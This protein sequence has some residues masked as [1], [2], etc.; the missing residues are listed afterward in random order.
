MKQK[1]KLLIATLFVVLFGAIWSLIAKAQT[2]PP[3]TDTWLPLIL[4]ELSSGEPPTF[5][6]T[7]TPVVI[8][9]TATPSPTPSLTPTSGV[10]PGTPHPGTPVSEL[11]RVIQINS[12][13]GVT[14]PE[15]PES[16]FDSLEEVNASSTICPLPGSY[17]GMIGGT[18]ST[19][20]VGNES[21]RNRAVWEGVPNAS[22]I[23]P[24]ETVDDV[25]SLVLG[26]D[27]VHT[28]DDATI[29]EGHEP[30]RVVKFV[31]SENAVD[32]SDTE[33]I[34][35]PMNQVIFGAYLRRFTSEVESYLIKIN[36]TTPVYTADGDR[37]SSAALRNCGTP[38]EQIEWVA[39]GPV[40]INQRYALQSQI[41]FYGEF[42]QPA[43][44]ACMG[45]YKYIEVARLMEIPALQAVVSD[46]AT[47]GVSSTWNWQLS[48][49]L[50]RSFAWIGWDYLTFFAVRRVEQGIGTTT[51][52]FI[53]PDEFLDFDCV[54]IDGHKICSVNEG[55]PGV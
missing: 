41:L 7:P 20:I 6:P 3:I 48:D 23:F 1:T 34:W 45:E 43:E 18:E 15:S 36:R 47:D 50:Q 55:V 54:T 22:F 40:R 9:V 10:T 13:S 8:I 17:V 51:M 32:A 53:I 21:Y 19:I 4:D 29:S 24:Y 28:L 30:F 25:N 14:F 16:C 5:T 38:G 35:H 26:D 37:V 52:W 31:M 33:Q 11:P 42:N 2:N 46:Y 39:I 44:R 27:I 49:G 12:T